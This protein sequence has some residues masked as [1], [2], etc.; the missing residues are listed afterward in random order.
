MLKR[1]RL[2]RIL[3]MVN[4]K[5]IV[6][7]AD[8]MEA[9]AVS[10]MTVRR[11]LDELEKSGKLI[12]VRGG[13]QSLDYNIDFELSHLQKSTVQ[14]EEKRDIA[15]YAA[16]LVQDHETIFLGPGTTLEMIA[17]MIPDKD[18]RIV[19]PSLPA[20]EVLK[21]RMEDRLLL[22]GG[23]YRS[24]TGAFVGPLTN[25][26]LRDLKFTKA[27]ISCNGI[28]D[29]E[30]TTSSMEEGEMQAIACRNARSTFLLADSRKFNREDFYVYDH[31]YNIDE[32]ITDKSVPKDVIDHYGEYTK[33]LQVK[34][35]E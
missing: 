5:G 32:L 7:T 13:A 6:D 21:E 22:V 10:D 17:S 3:Q 34:G 11:D 1:E 20:F 26:V 12:R 15:R 4:E 31:L 28:A 30:I 16:S 2:T 18:I 8:I 19:T 23:T 35:E 9:L 24:N 25:Q 29:D 14:I 33:I 27:F